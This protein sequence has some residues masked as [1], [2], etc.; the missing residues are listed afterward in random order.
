MVTNCWEA[1]DHK[2]GS[3]ESFVCIC[4]LFRMRIHC[5]WL[6]RSRWR[7]NKRDSFGFTEPF[8]ARYSRFNPLDNSSGLYHNN[9]KNTR[10]LREMAWYKYCFLGSWF[11]GR[12]FIR[13]N[14]LWNNGFQ[15]VVLGLWV[16]C[17]HTINF[18]QNRSGK[19]TLKEND[20]CRNWKRI[21]G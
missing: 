20:A 12:P 1:L 7:I 17:N 18:Y 10:R 4:R 5:L 11:L 15:K 19:S 21:F 2:I 8:Y 16:N 9:C 3:S 14:S 13:L 6:H